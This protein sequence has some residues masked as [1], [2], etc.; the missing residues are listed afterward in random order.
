MELSNEWVCG[1]VDGEG[2]FYVGIEKH[3]EMSTGYQVLPEFTVVQHERDIQILYGLKKF[4]RGGVVRRNHD[5][6]FSFRVRRLS[7]LRE[8][9][10]F[11]LQHP[12]K[13]KKNVDFR[14]FRRVILLMLER[15]HLDRQGLIEIVDIAMQ[16][17]FAQRKGKAIIIV[18]HNKN[19][20]ALCTKRYNLENGILTYAD[21]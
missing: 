8:I 11:F 16:M 1:F 4:F 13:T 9:S 15:K 12:L 20:A 5:D 18:T 2:C 6:R 21:T 17:N 19:L 10:D 3:P 14:K 7:A